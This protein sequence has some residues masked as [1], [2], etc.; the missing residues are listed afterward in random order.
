M[1]GVLASGRAGAGRSMPGLCPSFVAASGISNPGLTFLPMKHSLLLLALLAG[2]A[3]RASAQEL[4]TVGTVAAPA[5]PA[6]PDTTAARPRLMLGFTAGPTVSSFIGSDAVDTHYRAGFHAGLLAEMPISPRFVLHTEA[7]YSQK[8]SQYANESNSRNVVLSYADLWVL[9]RFYSQTSPAANAFFLE[10]GP[11][12]SALLAARNDN[13]QHSTAGLSPV[14]AGFALGGG[15]RLA[16]GIAL[17][18][19]YDV[20]VTPVYKTIPADE[21]RGKGDYRPNSTNDAFFVSLSFPLWSR[22]PAAPVAPTEAPAQQ[23]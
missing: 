2:S 1:P 20:G 6:A 16:N 8:G 12:V 21:T 5:P 4:T 23:P 10:F 13:G 11:R 3:G 19:R 7:L 14:D 22:Q 18:L 15:Y 17:G 9:A